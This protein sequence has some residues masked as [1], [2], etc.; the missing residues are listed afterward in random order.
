MMQF[1][2]SRTKLTVARWLTC[3]ET[4]RRVSV[5][6]QKRGE[7][8]ARHHEA[9]HIN[10]V[11]GDNYAGN[12]FKF[13]FEAEHISY[14]SSRKPKSEIYEAFEPPLNAGEIELR[15]SRKNLPEQL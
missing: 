11:V 15:R 10:K 12:T 7:K 3:R 5:Q 8:F 2:R 6:S 1:Y 14:E 13:D 9:V 4:G